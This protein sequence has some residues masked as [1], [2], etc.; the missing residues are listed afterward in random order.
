[1]QVNE[2]I[3]SFHPIIIQIANPYGIGTGFY[4]KT[5]D[6]IITNEH[7]VRGTKDVIISGKNFQK[8]LSPVMFSDTKYDLAFIQPPENTIFPEKNFGNPESVK[9][10]DIVIAIGHPYGLNYTATE[11]IVSRAKRL[12]NNL[13]YI[14]IDA[15]I[16]PG[17][18]GGPL[19]NMQGEIIGVNTFIIAGGSNLGFALP[20]N[21]LLESLEDYKPYKGKSALRCS[22]CSNIILEEDLQDKYCP[23][24]GAE[25]EEFAQKK[26]D[27]KPTGAAATIEKILE[28]LGKDVKLS[29][30]GPN[31][32]VVEAGSIK[33]YINYNDNGFITG[34]AFI[35]RL[36]KQKIAELYEF[37]LRENNNFEFIN[38]SIF[39]Q[40]VIL[41][42]IIYDQYLNFEVGLEAFQ[43]LIEK[44][45][46]YD[47]YLIN[48]FGASPGILEEQ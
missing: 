4:L 34:D 43:S 26:E 19:V 23:E 20:V 29:R 32:W 30:S 46:F 48:T 25:L 41:S 11:G 27:Y 47:D 2:I 37:L 7:V 22:S 31:R 6:L 5:Y 39:N 9:D 12:Y 40:T 10:G 8:V 42:T 28:K 33:I 17:N 16:N 18:S 13:N 1:M 38:F 35:C 21:Y 44:A 45:D 15:A 24:C 3:K 14:Q 36:P